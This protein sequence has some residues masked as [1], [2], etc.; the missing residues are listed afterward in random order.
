MEASY[1]NACAAI[2][3]I[4]VSLSSVEFIVNWRDYRS[5]GLFSW[6]VQGLRR[7]PVGDSRVTRLGAGLGSGGCFLAVAVVRLVSTLALLAILGATARLSAPL[8]L[9]VLL[10][11]AFIHARHAYG[12]DGSDQM[13][14]I[15]LAGLSIYACS[16]P[17]S[18][19]ATVGVCFVAFQGI[20]SYFTS[21]VAK[22][23]SARWRSGDALF[24]ILNTQSYGSRSLAPLLVE[25]PHLSKAV[26]WGVIVYEVLFPLAIFGGTMALV[27]FTLGVV[28]HAG[29]AASMG[30]NLF[31]WSFISTYPAILACGYVLELHG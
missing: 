7:A 25:H 23:M 16:A 29:I 11:T 17:G 24:A 6:S 4:G 28:M 31:F 10:T 21:G 19:A 1:V 26:N 8:V 30:L 3:G 9:V 12:L 27:I 13:T 14:T 20:L 18:L 22:A 15:V 5:T 2:A